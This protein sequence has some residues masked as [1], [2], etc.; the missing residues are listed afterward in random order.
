MPDIFD[1]FRNS[2]PTGGSLQRVEEAHELVFEDS[3]SGRGAL[4]RVNAPC[5]GFLGMTCSYPGQSASVPV[6][7][8]P[9]TLPPAPRAAHTRSADRSC[10]TC[11]SLCGDE[12]TEPEWR[13][14]SD[15]LAEESLSGIGNMN[16]WVGR[17][18]PR[19]TS[20]STYEDGC[21]ILPDHPIDHSL[22]DT[23]L[24]GKRLSTQREGVGKM[25][26]VNGMPDKTRGRANRSCET[27]CM[28]DIDEQEL[29]IGKAPDPR[30][31]MPGR[32]DVW[33]RITD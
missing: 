31:Q 16:G 8:H 30:T 7:Q 1:F 14:R 3:V 28:D 21:L 15:Q 27:T 22:R 13:V 32:S 26:H 20:S 11:E 4:H 19:G 9:N 33:Y 6:R 2:Q 24:R 25:G 29:R 12:I 10:Q 5:G 17:Q 18:H 23:N